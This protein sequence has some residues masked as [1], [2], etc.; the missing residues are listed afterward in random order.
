LSIPKDLR[1]L[2]TNFESADGLDING[3]ITAV[4][5]RQKHL[6]SGVL[7]F[8]AYRSP[9]YQASVLKISFTEV[10]LVQNS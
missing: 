9:K 6:N 7:V 1:T 8:A 2:K 3:R 5:G 10:V 4:L